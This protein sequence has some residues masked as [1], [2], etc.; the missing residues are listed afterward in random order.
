MR[1]IM[2]TAATAVAALL[3]A[4]AAAALVEDRLDE[5]YVV[6]D[7]ATLSLENVNGD[8]VIEAWDQDEVRVQALR[9]AGNADALERVQVLIS[10]DTDRIHIETKLGSSGKFWNRGDS[11]GSV[12]YTIKVPAHLNLDEVSSVNGPVVIEGVHG[13]VKASTVNGEL[14]AHGLRGDADLETVNGSVE[15]R[16]EQMAEGQRVTAD[17]VNGAVRIYLPDDAGV[18]VTAESV[19]GSLQ[20][21]FGLKVTK[22]RWVGAD[23]EGDIGDGGATLKAET[24]NGSVRILRMD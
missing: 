4:G 20:N 22:G 16:F 1:T 12:D 2:K 10:A 7:G 15:A 5:T 6:E 18:S 19:N 11:K 9:K 17:S 24:V 21:D 3:F 8:V 13:N 14:K 23:M